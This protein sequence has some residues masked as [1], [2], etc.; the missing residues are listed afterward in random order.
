MWWYDSGRHQLHVLFYV[1][2]WNGVETTPD[3]YK[4][5]FCQLHFG[6]HLVDF[7][8]L[9]WTPTCFKSHVPVNPSPHWEITL[10]ASSALHLSDLL[11]LL[12]RATAVL[13]STVPVKAHYCMLVFPSRPFPNK[14]EHLGTA[15]WWNMEAKHLVLES[16]FLLLLLCFLYDAKSLREVQTLKLHHISSLNKLQLMYAWVPLHGLHRSA[17]S[18]DVCIVWRKVS[19]EEDGCAPC[20]VLQQEV[21]RKDGRRGPGAHPPSALVSEAKCFE[22]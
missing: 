15:S 8:C 7:P 14:S 17:S 12:Q 6:K 3:R 4:P 19:Q 2:D 16:S 20:S 10:M 18:Q 13:S 21:H 22:H 11:K 1:A 5:A 9:M